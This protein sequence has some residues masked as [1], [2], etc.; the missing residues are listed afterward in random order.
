M[1][2]GLNNGDGTTDGEE[3]GIQLWWY[4]KIDPHSG[5]FYFNM[6]LTQLENLGPGFWGLIFCS[7]LNQIR[8]RLEKIFLIKLDILYNKSDLGKIRKMHKSKCK[9]SFV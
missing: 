5:D 7:D 3:T 2:D 8:S 4:W 9:H 6:K 1:F